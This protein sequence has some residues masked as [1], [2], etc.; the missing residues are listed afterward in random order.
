[1]VLIFD[2]NNKWMNTIDKKYEP[3]NVLENSLS[4]IYWDRAIITD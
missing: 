2:I 4:K 1:M 3:K